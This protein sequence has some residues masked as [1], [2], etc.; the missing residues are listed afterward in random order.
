MEEGMFGLSMKSNRRVFV[1][2]CIAAVLVGGL[3]VAGELKEKFEKTLPFPQGGRF[4]LRNTN[5]AVQVQTWDRNEVRIEAEKRVRC[6]SQR[7]AERLMREIEIRIDA[8]SDYVRVDTDLPRKNSGFWDWLF[9]GG[10]EQIEV[11]YLITLPKRADTRLSNTNGIVEV[12]D[13][14]GVC[15]ANTTNGRIILAGMAGSMYAETT[16]GSIELR[17]IELI[18]NPEVSLE[19]TNGGIT[20][21]LPTTFSGSVY[22]ET[23]NGRIHS[24]FPVSVERGFSKNRL[25]G[26]IGTGDSRLRLETTNGSIK[27]IRL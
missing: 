13:L 18:G 19:T 22:A 10:S 24:D 8:G 2:T 6:G 7:E 12:H 20:A 27:L 16:N 15:R 26:R 1:A 21:E 17:M 5:G 3:A 23:T 4:E 11:A 25:E 9:E 14:T